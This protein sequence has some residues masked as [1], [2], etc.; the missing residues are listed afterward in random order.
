MRCRK[1][2][3]AAIINM[4]QHKLALCGEHYDEWFLS[5]TDR[6]IEKYRMFSKQD[7]VLVAVSGGKDSLSLWEA[8]VRLGYRADALYIGLGINDKIPYSDQSLEKTRSFA[9]RYPESTLHVVDI[10]GT[11]GKSIPEIAHEKTRGHGK[12]CAACGLTKRYVMNRV[13]ARNG[14]A[15]L[16]TGHNLDDEVAV[17]M[18]NTLRWQ[19]GYLARQAPVL[20][21][22][23][24]GLAKKAKPFCRF[25]ERETATYALVR[26]IDYIYVE[27]PHAAGNLTNFYKTLL[28]QLEAQSPG[29][30][31]GFYLEFLRAR[32]NGLFEQANDREKLHECEVC[33]QPTSAPGRCAFCRMWD[34]SLSDGVPLSDASQGSQ[35]ETDT[36]MTITSAPN[37]D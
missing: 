14:Y 29:A 22:S 11:Y 15:V 7:R 32:Q 20:P 5:Q 19:A 2:G 37:G 3:D 23:D 13:A 9:A 8:L 10:K 36:E 18:Q 30:K 34:I 28:N 26:G 24:S 4:R 12:P 33:G 16:A 6:T 31:L 35:N 1:C 17:L 27:C 21:P 25:Y